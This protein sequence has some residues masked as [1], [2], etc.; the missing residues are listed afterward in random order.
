MDQKEFFY[1]YSPVLYN[2][3]KFEKNIA[4]ICTGRHLD[5]N[6]QF[7]QFWRS[8]DLSQAVKEYQE[9]KKVK[10]N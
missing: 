1:C 6:K 7:W 8:D 2:F 4:F 3:L 10:N 5:T 9:K